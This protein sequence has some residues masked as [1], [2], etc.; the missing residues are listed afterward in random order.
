MNIQK[1]LVLRFSSLGDI[2][3]LT[4]LFREIKRKYPSARLD[5]ITSTTFQKICSNNPH[6][7]RIIAFDRKKGTNELFRV[8][9]EIKLC[10]Y[11]LVFDAHRSLRSRLLLML[12]LGFPSLK[13]KV[14]KID[15]RS[16]KRNLLI[17]TKINLLKE[18]VSQREAYCQLLGDIFATESFVTDT[19]LFPEDQ[20]ENRVNNILQQFEL[21][22]KPIIALGPGSSFQG[23]TWPKERYLELSNTLQEMGFTVVIL[24]GASDIEPEWIVENSVRKPIN[25]AGKLSFL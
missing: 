15:K 16:W 6:I 2:I 7:D 19:E 23:K 18:S 5:F 17:N 13:R 22:G 20:E 12:G 4:P 21:E 25:L 24:G 1:I 14:L 3:L 8:A 11:D 10:E 9:K